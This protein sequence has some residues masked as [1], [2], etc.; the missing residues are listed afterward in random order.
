MM[1]R[2]CCN[3]RATKPVPNPAACGA[4][5]SIFNEGNERQ[6]LRDGAN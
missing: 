3:L 2:D 5:G 1:T 6:E 4:A